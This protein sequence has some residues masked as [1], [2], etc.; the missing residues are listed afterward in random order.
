MSRPQ[1]QSP[2]HRR[3][4]AALRASLCRQVAIRRG[5]RHVCPLI[6]LLAEYASLGSRLPFASQQTMATEL[7]VTDRTIR[8]WLVVLE[9]LAVVEVFRSRP[10]LRHGR[11]TRRTNRYLLCDRRAAAAPRLCPVPRRRSFRVTGAGSTG[12]ELPLTSTRYEPTGVD[13]GVG[14]PPVPVADADGDPASA[15]PNDPLCSGAARPADPAVAR[16]FLA[17]ARAHLRRPPS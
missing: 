7:G 13:L 10:M 5:Y 4:E 8:N 6:D 3:R 17:E 16:R 14:D 2:A 15:S 1:T 11:W 12:N 9:A